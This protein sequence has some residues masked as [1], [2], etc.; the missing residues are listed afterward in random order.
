[1]TSIAAVTAASATMR[2]STSSSVVVP[3]L[4]AALPTFSVRTTTALPP[5][6]S[7]C[8]HARMNTQELDP[9]ATVVALMTM[10]ALFAAAARPHRLQA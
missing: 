4:D 10:S 5:D 7:W 9:E 2:S 8:D 3:N 1:V 6:P